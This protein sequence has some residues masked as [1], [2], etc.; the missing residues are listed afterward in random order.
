MSESKVYPVD[1]ALAASAHCDNEKYERMYRQ[2]VEDPGAFWG[3]EGKRI[4]WI[5]PYTKVQDVR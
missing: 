3:E 5:R 2:S 1:P 4:D